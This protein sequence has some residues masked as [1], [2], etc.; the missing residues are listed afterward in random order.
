[1]VV[2]H[3]RR[4][5]GDKPSSLVQVFMA[6]ILQV[7]W[8]EQPHQ[9]GSRARVKQVGGGAKQS[10]R[11]RRQAEVVAASGPGLWAVWAKPNAHPLGLSTAQIASVRKH[12]I[13]ESG[14]VHPLLPR[15]E[16]PEFIRPDATAR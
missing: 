11:Q 10:L 8:V 13:V 2:S 4:G 5:G 9:T 7:N 12:R 14:H 1:M 3:S 16:F 15:R 6:M